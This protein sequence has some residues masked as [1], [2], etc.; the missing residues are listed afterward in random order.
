MCSRESKSFSEQGNHFFLWKRW[1]RHCFA[2]FCY[3]SRVEEQEGAAARPLGALIHEV[4]STG[5]PVPAGLGSQTDNKCCH[6][7]PRAGCA[8][9]CAGPASHRTQPCLHTGLAKSCSVHYLMDYLH[10]HQQEEALASE[11][12]EQP[13]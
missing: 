7:V 8:E 2:L 1:H 10:L 6:L 4:W 13:R 11:R 3:P 12:V 5:V 9:P